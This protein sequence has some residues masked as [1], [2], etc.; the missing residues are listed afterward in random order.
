MDVAQGR[1]VEYEV[2]LDAFSQIESTAKTRPIGP[3][4]GDVPALQFVSLRPVLRC[5]SNDS[6]GSREW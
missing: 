3:A 1:I 5:R 4:R 2:L 6:R